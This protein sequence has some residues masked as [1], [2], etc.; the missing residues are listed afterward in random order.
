MLPALNQEKL[1]NQKSVVMNERRQRY[2]NQPYG[3]AWELLFSNLYSDHHP[4]SWPTIGW[5]EDIAAFG[6]EDISNFFRTYYVPN[7]ASLVIAGDFDEKKI[8]D[9]VKK[10][11]DEIPR[12]DDIE[13]IKFD[14]VA[15]TQNLFVEHEDNVE[16]PRL[17]LAWHSDKLYGPDDAALDFTADILGGSKN[18]RLHKSMVHEKQIAQDVS[19]FQYSGKLKGTFIVVC[20]AKPGTS[21][22]LLK[23]EIFNQLGE[24]FEEG[25]EDN[26]LVRARNSITSSY[27]YS[28]QNLDIIANQINNYN[29]NI[30]KPDYFKEDLY[31]YESATKS[32]IES[33]ARKYLT[34]PYTELHII[35][36]R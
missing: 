26:E 22:E 14:D 2:E 27:I 32:D 19:C 36:K 5:M 34:R 29:C 8:L 6:L 7:N 12:G 23:D 33:A 20:T 17:Y 31:R 30:G 11:F 1:D 21:L 4:Y 25:I 24:L 9:T 28:L 15:L 18:S 3:R 35:K 13:P 16:L 10:Y